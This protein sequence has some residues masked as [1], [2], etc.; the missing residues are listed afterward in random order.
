MGPLLFLKQLIL[1][2]ICKDVQILFKR[3]QWHSS[4]L[5]F[6]YG[7]MFAVFLCQKK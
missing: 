3:S 1:Q 6:G 4:G 7:T 2:P 5:L